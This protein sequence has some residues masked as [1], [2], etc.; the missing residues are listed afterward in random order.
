MK[1][2]LFGLVAALLFATPALASP[3][4]LSC[5]GVN[6][7]TP[8]PITVD[9][10]QGTVTAAM[11]GTP[12]TEPALFTATQITWDM[13]VIYRLTFILDR[14]TL[15]LISRSA[16]GRDGHATCKVVPTPNRQV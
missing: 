6:G 8:T 16:T 1:K 9:E 7:G 11:M 2:L 3:V 5:Q 15:E 14:S 10:T 4:Y 13:V 12:D